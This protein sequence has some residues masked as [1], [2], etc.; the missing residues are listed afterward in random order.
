M[1]PELM[2]IRFDLA[3]KKLQLFV[4]TIRSKSTTQQQFDAVK[5]EKETADNLLKIAQ[6]Q[7]FHCKAN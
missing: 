3:S 4:A 7:F 2:Q 6:G 1:Q 5:A